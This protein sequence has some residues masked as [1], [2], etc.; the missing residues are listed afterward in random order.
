MSASTTLLI[1][2]KDCTVTALKL[3]IVR[4]L[5]YSS[6]CLFS[7]HR[8]LPS[9]FKWTFAFQWTIIFF[10]K[11]LPCG[12]GVMMTV[13]L[14]RGAGLLIFLTASLSLGLLHWKSVLEQKKHSKLVQKQTQFFLLFSPHVVSQFCLFFFKQSFAEREREKSWVAWAGSVTSGWWCT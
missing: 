10:H 1:A 4:K 7:V 6:V 12:K 8:S 9:S 11:T 13:W 2:A 5:R 14:L 3:L